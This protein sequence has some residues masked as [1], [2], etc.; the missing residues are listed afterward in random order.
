M[1]R[2]EQVLSLYSYVGSFLI[3]GTSKGCRVAA[4]QDNGSLVMGPLLFTDVIVDDAVA[5]DRFVYVTVRDKG[6]AG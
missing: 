2:G 6:E 4:I 5:S 3:V 1:P